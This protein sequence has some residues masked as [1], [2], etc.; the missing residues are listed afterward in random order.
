MPVSLD[1]RQAEEIDLRNYA[2]PHCGQSTFTAVDKLSIGVALPTQCSGCGKN[3]GVPLKSLWLG[4]LLPVPAVFTLAT[5]TD[6]WGTGM[7]IQTRALFA[8]LPL[9][10]TVVLGVLYSRVIPLVRR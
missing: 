1:R 10:L 3:V 2:C 8:L 6:S 5:L 9:S 7:P 4:L